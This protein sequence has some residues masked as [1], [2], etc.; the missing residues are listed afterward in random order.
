MTIRKITSFVVAAMLGFA[1]TACGVSEGTVIDKEF[2]PEWTEQ[3]EQD[4]TEEQCEWDTDTKRVKVGKTYTTKT[5]KEYECEDVVV[6]TEMVDKVHPDK[7]EITVENEDGDT[8]VLDVTE[9]EFESVE[10]GD[11]FGG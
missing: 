9:A 5:T 2:I 7:W 10:V 4:V 3:V 6:G 11:F 8:G 1:L